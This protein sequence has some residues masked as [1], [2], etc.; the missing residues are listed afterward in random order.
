MGGLAAELAAHREALC[1]RYAARS[2]LAIFSA[3]R[4]DPGLD[5]AALGRELAGSGLS[6]LVINA[7]RLGPSSC[8]VTAVA[9]CTNATRT[10]HT[11]VE[12]HGQGCDFEARL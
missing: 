7:Q 5:T 12:D 6:W 10:A 4:T 11:T 3:T 8:H 9:V 2:G 1:A